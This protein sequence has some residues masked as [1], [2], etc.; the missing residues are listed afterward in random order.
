M[1]KFI[2]VYLTI[3][4][5]GFNSCQAQEKIYVAFWNL[6]NLFDTIDDPSNPGDDEYLPTSKSQWDEVKFDKKL[7]NLS[8]IIRSMNDGNGPD[9]LG[10][11]EVEN[12]YVLEELSKRFLKDMNFEIVHFDS[13][14]PRGIDVGLFFK[15]NKFQ[16]IHSEKIQ[17]PLQGNTRDILYTTLKFKDDTLNIFVNHWPSRRG[18]E[19]ESEPRRIKAATALRNKVDSLLGKNI[20]ANIVIM[21]DFNDMPDNKSILMTLQAIPFDCD[22]LAPEYTYNLYNTAYKKYSQGLGSYFHQGNFNMLDQIIISKAL[23]DKKKLD[24]ECDSFSIISNELNTTR[25]GRYKGAPY[26]TFGSGRYLSGYSDHF[27][28]GASFIYI[29]KK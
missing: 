5:I 24:Y 18:G 7:S 6:E 20:S 29:G 13:K 14:D 25:S 21:G 26:P 12:R 22:N 15:K 4:S 3:I 10:V 2:L 16:V 23:L 28:V 27:P 1:R 17:V 8:K 19:L 9:I 11:C